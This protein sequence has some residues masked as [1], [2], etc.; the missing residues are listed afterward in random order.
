[1]GIVIQKAGVLDTLQ[2]LGRNG[3]RKFGINPNGAMDRN[4]LRVI[5]SLLGNLENEAALE[6]HFPA[7]TILFEE[8]ATFVLGGG[9][10][11]ASLDKTS[12]ENCAIYTAKN[13]S[14]LKF[15]RKIAGNRC[16]LAVRNGFE[17]KSWLGSASTN[18][19]AKA[20]GFAGRRLNSN[21]RIAFQSGANTAEQEDR[22][23]VAVNLRSEIRSIKRV[24]ITPGAEYNRLTAHSEQKLRKQNFVISNDSNRMGFRLEGEPLHLLNESEILS[25]AV[26]FGTIQLLPSGQMVILMADHQTTGGY[27]RIGHVIQRDLSKLAQRGAGDEIKFE[28]VTLEEAERIQSDFERDLSLLRMGVRF[29]S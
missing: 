14:V 7:P 13:G 9:N 11:D 2:D 25:S 8:P 20:G 23:R 5:N 4:S 10:F 18:L 19:I 17:T 21:D 3:Y 16:Y 15:K 26:N 24:R 1:M 27:P 28:V 6:M 12:L 22:L 29:K